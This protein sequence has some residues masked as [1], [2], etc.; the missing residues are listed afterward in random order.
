[1]YKPG[2]WWYI[3]PNDNRDIKNWQV[4]VLIIQRRR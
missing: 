4:D 2:L 1:M 3:G